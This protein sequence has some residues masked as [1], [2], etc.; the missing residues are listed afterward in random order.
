MKKLFTRSKNHIVE[1]DSIVVRRMFKSACNKLTQKSS[2]G[3]AVEEHSAHIFHLD[4]SLY[5]DGL[6]LD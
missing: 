5:Q 3:K 1:E 4:L 6:E 2:L